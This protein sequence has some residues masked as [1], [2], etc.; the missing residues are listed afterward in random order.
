MT[1]LEIIQEVL[2]KNTKN[3]EVLMMSNNQLLFRTIRSIITDEDEI[4]DVMQNTYLKAYEHL[5]TFKGDSKFSTWLVKIGLNE[6]L[7]NRNKRNKVS[8]LNEYLQ[9]TK[10]ILGISSSTRENPDKIMMQGELKLL[11]ENAIDKLPHDQRVIFILKEV[12]GLKHKEIGEILNMSQENVK[13][14]LHRAKNSL[15]VILLKSSSKSGLFEFG[16]QKC[17]MI[18]EKVMDHIV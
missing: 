16:N 4:L 15:K 11:L 6:A 1:E 14:K 12:E 7:A 2:N 13:V 17:D 10:L 8:I 5:H 18:I 3:F 9:E